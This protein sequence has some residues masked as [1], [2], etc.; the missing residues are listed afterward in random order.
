[1]QN[2]GDVFDLDL[3]TILSY[4]R[5]FSIVKD[6]PLQR[7]GTALGYT[8]WGKNTLAPAPLAYLC[9]IRKKIKS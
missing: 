8:T 5:A 1:M 2:L 3:V 6:S 9:D 7:E 4:P